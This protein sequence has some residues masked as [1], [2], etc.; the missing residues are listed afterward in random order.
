MGSTH[1]TF[2]DDYLPEI[3]TLEKIVEQDDTSS[4]DEPENISWEA[5][6]QVIQESHVKL[7]AYHRQ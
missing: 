2:D 6:K 4:D 5:A 3:P 7:D 1:L